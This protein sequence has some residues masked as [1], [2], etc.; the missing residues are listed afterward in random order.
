MITMKDFMETEA[1]AGGLHG[2]L[3]KKN[4]TD[5]WGPDLWWYMDH[6]A[7]YTPEW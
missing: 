4:R 6:V 5:L 1:V 3:P 7:D 2:M